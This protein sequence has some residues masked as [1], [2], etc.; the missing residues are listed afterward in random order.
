MRS[1]KR[2]VGG[3]EYLKREKDSL[4]WDKGKEGVEEQEKESGRR[5]VQY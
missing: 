4:I 2:K 5:G 1:R 3:G